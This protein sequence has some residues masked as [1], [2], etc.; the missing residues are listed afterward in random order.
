MRLA[1]PFLTAAALLA[2]S[3]DAAKPRDAILLSQ[4]RSAAQPYPLRQNNNKANLSPCHEQ[5]ESLTLRGGQQTTHRRVPALPQLKCVSH[6]SLCAKYT[7]DLMRCENKGAGY[8][9]E[10]IQWSCHTQLPPELKLGATDVICE[11]YTGP[12][13]PYVLKG[14]CGVEYRLALTRE[15]EEKWPDLAGGDGEYRDGGGGGGG[16]AV[17]FWIIFVA[18]VGWIVYSAWTEGRQNRNGNNRGPRPAGGNNG[19]FWGGGGGGGGDDGWD[20][21]PP[22]YPGADNN[23]APRRNYKRSSSTRNNNSSRQAGSGN[24]WRDSLLGGAA[25]AAAGYYFGSRGRNNNNGGYEGGGIG[26]RNYGST[27]GS[28]G[29]GSSRSGSSSSGS[30]ASGSRYES[31]GFGSTSR[32]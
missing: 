11:G 9:T 16:F 18:V 5:V 22:P 17:L 26:G 24:G 31:T 25:G 15:G 23:N 27:W 3:A 1:N 6:P 2:L 20:D 19:N 21:P 13:D 10:D 4:V 12:D 8:D 14:S 32:R 7:V 29:A 28:G 30:A